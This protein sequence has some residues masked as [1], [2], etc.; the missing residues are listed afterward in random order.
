MFTQHIARTRL[1][2]VDFVLQASF[3]CPVVDEPFIDGAI[4]CVV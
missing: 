3:H 2:L 4:G 1:N